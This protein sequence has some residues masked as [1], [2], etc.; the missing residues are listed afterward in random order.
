MQCLK[1]NHKEKRG[2]D[3][4]CTHCGHESVADAPRDGIGDKGIKD[5]TDRLSPDGSVCFLRRHIAY[6]IKRRFNQKSSKYRAWMYVSLMVLFVVLVLAFIFDNKSLQTLH[7]KNDFLGAVVEFVT[8]PVPMIIVGLVAF[9]A[10]MAVL[11]IRPVPFKLVQRFFEV[12][13]HSSQIV[14]VDAVERQFEEDTPA[15]LRIAVGRVLVCERRDIADFLLMNKFQLTHACPVIGPKGN[16]D[17]LYPSMVDDAKAQSADVFVL[18]NLTPNG[19]KFA[20]K[21]KKSSKWFGKNNDVTVI[22]LGLS[23][24]QRDQIGRLMVPLTLIP[25]GGSG[26]R[27]EKGAEVTLVR[28]K[29]LLTML[30]KC[31]EEK[32]PFDQLAEVADNYDSSGGGGT[33]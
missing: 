6:E 15:E 13:P 16:D 19:L 21:V 7:L 31:L 8:H 26:S 18:H 1:C 2:S 30:G 29:M 25:D 5:I 10:V 17:P 23:D 12:N 9:G 22:D 20:E 11:K 27:K 28:P 3:T 24:G 14:D 4:S 33:E 32:C